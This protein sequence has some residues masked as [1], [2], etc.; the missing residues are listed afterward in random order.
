MTVPAAIRELEKIEI[1]RINSGV[2][3]L[4]HAVTYTQEIILNSFGISKDEVYVKI[5]EIS[6]VLS[7]PSTVAEEIDDDEED[8][9]YGEM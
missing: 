7:N 8:E 4:D 9:S 3:Q 1:V 5:G 6:K 2:Y